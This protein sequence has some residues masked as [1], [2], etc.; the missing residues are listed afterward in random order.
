[1]GF[2]RR[3]IND[4]RQALVAAAMLA[5]A[6]P[7]TTAF[8][9]DDDNSYYTQ[10]QRDHREHSNFHGDVSEAHSRAHE[11]GFYSGAEHRAYHRALR[12][13]HGEFH[14]IIPEPAM[15]TTA[16]GTRTAIAT[17]TVTATDTSTLTGAYRLR[18][19]TV[20]PRG[21]VSVAVTVPVA[22][23]VLVSRSCS[24]H[25]GFRDD[26]RGIRHADPQRP[27]I[28]AVLGATVEAFLMC[29]AVSFA[30]IAMEVRVLPMVALMLSV[31]A[32]VVVVC[33]RRRGRCR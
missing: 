24:G 7:A 23:A 28:G 15:T 13:L 31:V 18:E 3:D 20:S 19:L 30:D 2:H 17:G 1:L 21:V 8:A 22:I 4:H 16:T 27:V 9:H 12:D 10:H 5:L 14:E 33:E 26:P 29:A 25:G 11:E 6:A 32:V